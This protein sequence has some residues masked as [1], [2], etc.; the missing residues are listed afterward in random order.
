MCWPLSDLTSNNSTRK[1]W[2]S[3]ITLVLIEQLLFR[4]WRIVTAIQNRQLDATGL[5][6]IEMRC[7]K[8]HKI[9]SVAYLWCSLRGPFSSFLRII[10]V[11][12]NKIL[13]ALLELCGGNHSPPPYCFDADTRVRVILWPIGENS[14]KFQQEENKNNYQQKLHLP[15]WNKFYKFTW[16]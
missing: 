1:V 10:L 2:Q 13:S 9:I 14:G 4:V 7:T 8:M 12:I 15:H 6:P 11:P 5:N 3:I 16:Q